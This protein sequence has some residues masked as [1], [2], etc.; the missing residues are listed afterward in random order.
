MNRLGEIIMVA[1]PN[2]AGKTSFAR[3][4]LPAQMRDYTF[5]NADEIAKRL[6]STGLTQAQIDLRA[7][8]EMLVRI[9]NAITLG[10]DL[11]IETTLSSTNWARHIPGWQNRG[12]SVE[13]YYLR[14]ANADAAI[15]RVARRVA[16]GG[17]AIPVPVIRRRF[18]RSLTMLKQ[19]YE[20]IVDRWYVFDS[21][22]DGPPILAE[23]GAR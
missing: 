17:H 18:E 11:M 23:S 8:R 10:D 6:D 12:Y 13:L 5:V 19:V 3:T 4:F 22:E 1:G 14:L 21:V 20:P 9:A 15:A 2:G 16:T 7:G